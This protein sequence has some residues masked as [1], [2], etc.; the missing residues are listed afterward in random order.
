MAKKMRDDQA[1]KPKTK[2]GSNGFDVDVLNSLVGRI[3]GIKDD[4][5][6]EKGE[7]M[8]RCKSMH[9]DIKDVYK[10]AKVRGI[11]PKPLKQAIEARELNRR[12][13]ALRTDLADM[14]DQ[15]S[16]DQIRLCLGDLADT[17]LGSSALA[18]AAAPIAASIDRGELSIEFPG[19]GKDG[20]TVI[21]N[22]AS[23]E[24][25]AKNAE[26]LKGIKQ[27]PDAPAP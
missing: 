26:T 15:E 7:S 10:E 4:I 27:L 17:P 9:K 6:T 1:A 21:I 3:E 5:A 8:Q 16:Y 23:R 24:A 13:E 12:I 14:V 19:A 11:P 20:E 25:A 2:A 22:K 18:R